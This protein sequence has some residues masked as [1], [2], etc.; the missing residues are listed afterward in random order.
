[1]AEII[2]GRK[3]RP[4]SGNIKK[5]VRDAAPL[6]LRRFGR[7]NMEAAIDLHGIAVHYLALESFG[8]V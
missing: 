3:L 5:V 2:S 6:G 8:N 4:G 1:M 7:S